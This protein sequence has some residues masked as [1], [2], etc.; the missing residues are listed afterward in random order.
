MK[1]LKR[2][3]IL[4]VVL[5]LTL[6]MTSFAAAGDPGTIKNIEVVDASKTSVTY[7]DGDV[8][9][10]LTYSGAQANGMYLVLVLS[11]EGVPTASNILYV[12]QETASGTSVSFDNVYPTNIQDSYIYLAG[13]GMA[14]TKLGKINANGTITPSYLLGDVNS[15]GNRDMADISLILQYINGSATLT[16]VQSLSADVTGDSNQDMADVSSIL[17]FI[18]GAITEFPAEQ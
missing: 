1:N 17:Q 7:A 18:N 2:V 13:T 5:S 8:K 15:D 3:L 10:A 16:D 14:Y 9:F 4:L 11:E 12:N 6:G